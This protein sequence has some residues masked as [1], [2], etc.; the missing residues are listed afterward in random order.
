MACLRDEDAADEGSTRW[1]VERF[2]QEFDLRFLLK[3]VAVSSPSLEPPPRANQDEDPARS[4][5]GS[6]RS[7]PWQTWRVSVKDADRFSAERLGLKATAA[8]SGLALLKVRL[9]GG[10]VSCWKP[11]RSIRDKLRQ[12][13]RGGSSPS[14][15]PRPS[16]V[17]R[18]LLENEGLRCFDG[19]PAVAPGPGTGYG[20]LN[21]TESWKAWTELSEKDMDLV[22]PVVAAGGTI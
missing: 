11:S 4:E 5:E 10:P 20:F 2:L 12:T 7:H 3:T 9:A 15:L 22:M 6:C 16:K 21:T 17:V 13:F 18:I 8:A 19:G 1:M 14:A